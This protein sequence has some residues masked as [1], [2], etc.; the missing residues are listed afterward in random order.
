MKSKTYLTWSQ[1]VGCCWVFSLSAPHVGT[2]WIGRNSV[3][4]VRRYSVSEP[5]NYHSNMR[6]DSQSSHVRLACHE[7][8]PANNH[9]KILSLWQL[10]HNLLNSKD[11]KKNVEYRSISH[12]A[13]KLWID[14]HIIV[15]RM[16]S[17]TSFM[18]VKVQSS[19]DSWLRRTSQH[20][21]ASILTIWN[22]SIKHK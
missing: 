3:Q 15:I 1:K 8:P 2:R 9:V 17:I 13:T 6:S 20:T 22:A 19:K 16:T 12:F 14:A 5:H 18:I 10:K 21:S 4:F 11:G 7:V